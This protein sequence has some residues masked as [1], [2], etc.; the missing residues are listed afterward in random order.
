MR[1]ASGLDDCEGAEHIA[2][3]A[4]DYVFGARNELRVNLIA[5]IR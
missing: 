3:S 4:P 1:A 5:R 2:V